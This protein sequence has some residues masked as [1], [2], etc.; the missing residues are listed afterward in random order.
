MMEI[1][2]EKGIKIPNA[3]LVSGITGTEVDEEI[4]DFVKE[5]GSINRVIQIPDPSTESQKS[6]IVEYN[7]G[8]AVKNL[9]PLLPYVQEAK[10]NPEV[11]FHVAALPNVYAQKIGRDV[12][13]TYLNELK[14]LAKRSGE[15]YAEILKEML[16]HMAKLLTQHRIQS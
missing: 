16:T 14:V 13:Q 2:E 5:Y 4:L 10:G 11:S 7:S 8:Q 15:D 9:Q 1:I 6:L 12:T 3:I